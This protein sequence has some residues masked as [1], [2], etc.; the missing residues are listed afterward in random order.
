MVSCLDLT[1]VRAMSYRLLVGLILLGVALPAK[2]QQI[3]GFSVSRQW[4]IERIGENHWKLVGAVEMERDDLKVFADEIEVF[5]DTDR[6]IARGNVVVNTA[7]SRIAAD[8]A[9]L[10]T[11]TQRGTFFNAAGT[12]SL[13]D[14]IDRSLFGTLEPDA[15]FYGE[16]I[17][18]IGRQKYR[19]TRGGFTTCVQPTPRWE[20]TSSTVIL[21]LNDYA[22][23]KN[24]I[25]KVK[26]VPVLYLPVMYFP[27]QE[28]DRATGFLIP[29]YGNSS[30]RGH[31]IS[32]AFF[33]AI[34]RN[35][36]ATFLH[37]WFS[38]AGQ[39]RGGE[40]RYELGGGSA[41]S[42]RTYQLNE[43]ERVFPSTTGGVTTETT[44]PGRKSFELRGQA[45]HSVSSSVKATA[46]MDFFSDI[47]V[48]HT[49]NQNVFD[50]SSRS[51]T[52][53]GN[54]TGNWGLHALNA[55][56]DW[57]EIFFSETD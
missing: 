57:N 17:E 23:L 46:R 35:Q 14:R 12:A 36:D 2:A 51:R 54:L 10:N 4:T 30:F 50:F 33:W 38:Q 45:R 1:R 9:D 26:G 55:T 11:R 49:Y 37:D 20:V 43:P 22:V 25:L 34:S 13:G 42:V 40:Y 29:M 6:V 15:Y 48:R 56:F 44:Q 31:T 27:I 18:K 39:G 28:D 3:P 32:S 16:T 21:N 41:G 5:S 19:I 52:F 7:E 47:T 53:A 24:S 8:R